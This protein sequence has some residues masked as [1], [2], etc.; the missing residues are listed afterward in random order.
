M[1]F[2]AVFYAGCILSYMLHTD[3]LKNRTQ[4]EKVFV[5]GRPFFATFGY[6]LLQIGGPAAFILFIYLTNSPFGLHVFIGSQPSEGKE[7]STKD[8]GKYLFC[9]VHTSLSSRAV[10]A[11]C[12]R[13]FIQN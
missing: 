5:G 9:T 2:R 8:L 10:R 7:N 1:D 4:I 3:G 13:G 12:S 6:C 11:S